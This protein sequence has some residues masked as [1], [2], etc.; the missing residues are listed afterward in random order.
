MVN[1]KTYDIWMI[2]VTSFV[3]FMHPHF[4]SLS[5][6]KLVTAF[7]PLFQ[8]FK[9]NMVYYI[10]SHI[11]IKRITL[12]YRVWPVMSLFLKCLQHIELWVLYLWQVRPSFAN[13][14]IVSSYFLTLLLQDSLPLFYANNE[15][16]KL[17]WADVDRVIIFE[18]FRYKLCLTYLI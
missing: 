8:Q 10:I 2:C 15:V 5:C 9:L 6:S 13:W 17:S 12:C 3:F 1:S 14:S 7:Y 11:N 4:Q 16:Y 18:T